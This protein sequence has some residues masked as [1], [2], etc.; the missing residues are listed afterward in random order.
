ML[1]NNNPPALKALL[2]DLLQLT[3]SSSCSMFPWLLINK[4]N[5]FTQPFTNLA[6]S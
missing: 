6:A 5:T 3:P 1:L 4:Q 2:S